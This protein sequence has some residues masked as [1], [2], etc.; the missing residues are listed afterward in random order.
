MRRARRGAVE[1]LHRDA[2]AQEGRTRLHG[3]RE[4]HGDV[5]ERGQVSSWSGEVRITD[6]LQ[7][8]DDSY[9]A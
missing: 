6:S 4:G 3:D 5:G 1:T 7:G 2:Q 8:I 9:H